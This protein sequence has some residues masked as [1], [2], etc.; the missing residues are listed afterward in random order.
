MMQRS[1]CPDSQSAS[2]R[3]S[4]LIALAVEQA[5]GCVAAALSEMAGR[6]IEA[7]GIATQLVPV[8]MLSMVAGD[9]ERPMLMIYLGIEG[10]IR[11]HILL[12]LSEPMALALVDM[13][14]WQPA[15]TTSELGDMEIS[16]L[17]EAGNVSGS[18]FLNSIANSAGLML[19]PTPPVVF[20]EMFGAI[21]DTL[22]ADLLMMEQDEAMV[23]EAEFTCEGEAVDLAFL[24]FPAPQLTSAI[25]KCG[26]LEVGHAARRG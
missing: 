26:L 6:T 24:M 8:P 10:E 12:A 17:A 3:E 25:A 21:L 4:A 18:A 16:A 2:D 15:G 23:I 22:A 19:P 11:G 13:L 20:H 7:E 1:T 9:P 14:L 5:A